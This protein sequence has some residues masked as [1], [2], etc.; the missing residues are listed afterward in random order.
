MRYLARPFVAS[1]A[2]TALAASVLLVPAAAA[3]AVATEGN[4]A[5]GRAEGSGKWGYVGQ[6]GQLN[7]TTEATA[8]QFFLPYAIDI[9]GDTI[10][11]TDS[12]LAAGENGSKTIGHTVQTFTLAARPGSVGHGDY[13]GNGQYEVDDTKASLIDPGSIVN[14]RGLHYFEEGSPRGPR[15]VVVRQD[16]SLVMGTYQNGAGRLAT[17]AFDDADLSDAPYDFAGS[18]QWKVPGFVGG[19]VHVD[20]DSRNN[21]YVAGGT[22]ASVFDENGKFLSSVGQYF[23]AN[24]KNWNI[25][26]SATERHGDPNFI[27]ELYGISVVEKGDQ[28]IVFVGDTGVRWATPQYPATIK[29][30]IVEKTGGI[31]DAR[32]NPEGWKWMLDSTFGSNGQVTY[33]NTF[34][35]NTIFALEADSTSNVLHFATA[36]SSFPPALGAVDMTTGQPVAAPTTIRASDQQDS[37]MPY[38]RGL[39]VDD[40][41]L[42]YATTQNSTLA[43]NKR[44]IVQ[45]WGMTPTSIAD[46]AVAT[47]TATSVELA[48]DESTRGYQQTELL[49]YVV[50]YRAV[51]DTEWTIEPA[52]TPTSTERTRT[53]DDL[54][55]GTT[56]E[57]M[58]TPWNEAGSGTP[59]NITF[60]TLVENPELS[61]VKKG[62]GELAPTVDDAVSVTAGSQTAFTYDVTNT[63][64][65]PLSDVTVSDD[66]IA[67]VSAPGGFDGTLAVGETVTFTARG[68]I[69][70]GAYKN[71]ATAT[72]AESE[73]AHAEWHG[74]GVKAPEPT[75]P[76]VEPTDPPVKPTD[77]PVEPTDPPVEPTDPPVTP[78]DPPVKPTDPPVK[79]TDPPVKP[80]DPPVKPTDSPMVPT[81]VPAAPSSDPT[82]APALPITGA[83]G[84]TT[85]LMTLL[86]LGLV[87]GGVVIAGTRRRKTQ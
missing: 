25:I 57:A 87:L 16:D 52:A 21:L 46:T 35:V 7:T 83:D 82:P 2:A 54:A 32:W 78:T 13:V 64:D 45:I 19:A 22:Q 15:G 20:T 23:D 50:Q 17:R 33:A 26:S 38:V 10:A 39:S 53:I 85:A 65:V 12:G 44:A 75:D 61:V 66:R 14:P 76:P 42:L 49:D 30:F 43:T 40:E 72:S 79:P 68:T 56:Y 27:N 58:I 55:P 70:E 48:W 67:A 59:A 62:D 8:G 80:T 84:A 24:G 1:L 77:P 63:G 60:T 37:W 34:R 6:F 81:E 74:V 29:K 31:V 28:T 3:S 73:P 47:P 11:V 5:P 36:G 41:G 9:N 18:T 51:G 69:A 86:A 71:I 4:V